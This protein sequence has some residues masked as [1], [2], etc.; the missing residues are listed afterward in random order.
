[1]LVATVPK[2]ASFAMA[3]RLLSEGLIQQTGT[4][5]QMLA[6]LAVLSVVAGNLIA[7]AQ[8]SL[9]RMLAYSAIANVGFM[10]F[11]FVAG[12][13]AGY[14]AS[15]YYTLAYVLMTVAAFGV[16][17][18][19]SRE[20]FEADQLD[21]YKGLHQ[22]DPLLAGVLAAV[23]F[24]TAGIPP[25]VGFWAKLRV[26][27]ALLASGHLWLSLIAVLASV[28][29]A[30]Y[31][32]RVVWLMYFDPPGELPNGARQSPIR[33][34]LA[35]NALAILALGLLPGSLLDLCRQVIP[36]G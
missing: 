13:A 16:V 11:G 18:F 4:W 27:E 29:G 21:H 20:G 36:G 2:L 33:W 7:I 5:T 10:L 17:L 12:S 9:L 32:L 24:S 19:V 1:M 26:I 34:V 14:E 35:L 25:F 28:I 23:M 15:L 6:I 22:R 3:F 31:Y 8:T 30:F